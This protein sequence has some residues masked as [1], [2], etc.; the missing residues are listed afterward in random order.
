MD[1][2]VCADEHLLHPDPFA[3]RAAWCAEP[4]T[5]AAT[6][7]DGVPFREVSLGCPNQWDRGRGIG[8]YLH[9]VILAPVS[10]SSREDGR[11]DG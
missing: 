7:I 6:R 5:K 4:C 3:D 9:E 2:S 1:N 8:R 11:D 10:T